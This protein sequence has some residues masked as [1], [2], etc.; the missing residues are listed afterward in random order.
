MFSR[1]ALEHHVLR[2]VVTK[3]FA[4]RIVVARIVGRVRGSLTTVEKD[5]VVS[6]HH[7]CTHAVSN[8]EKRKVFSHV[9]ENSQRELG[10]NRVVSKEQPFVDPKICQHTQSSYWQSDRK[11]RREHHSKKYCRHVVCDTIAQRERFGHTFLVQ[12][13]RGRCCTWFQKL[14]T[15]SGK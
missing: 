15:F 10:L 8:D 11:S 1:F 2:I 14:A 9:L 13:D 5:G 12:L 6:E 7:E 3:R 4:I